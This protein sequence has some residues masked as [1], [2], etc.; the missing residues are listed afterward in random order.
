MK[1]KELIEKL[2]KFDDE[3]EVYFVRINLEAKKGKYCDISDV[4]EVE[5]K[6]EIEEQYQSIKDVVI[7]GRDNE[8]KQWNLVDEETESESTT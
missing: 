6:F 7:W 8:C 4:S 2:D 3:A 5:F 1:K